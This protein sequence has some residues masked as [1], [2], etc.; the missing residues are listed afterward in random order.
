M[1]HPW[2]SAAVCCSNFRA[3]SPIAGNASCD[4]RTRTSVGCGQPSSSTRPYAIRGGA[5]SAIS[6]AATTSTAVNTTQRNRIRLTN[7]FRRSIAD[8]DSTRSVAPMP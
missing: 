7:W 3:T 4:V 2:F 8:A 6:P 1:R 5:A